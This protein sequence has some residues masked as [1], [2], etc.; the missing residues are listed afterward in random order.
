M[1]GVQSEVIVEMAPEM[2]IETYIY[3][4]FKDLIF[5]EV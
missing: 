1:H 3:M 5:S 4:K 2:K